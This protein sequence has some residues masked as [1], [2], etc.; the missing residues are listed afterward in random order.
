MPT[1]EAKLVEVIRPCD[2]A[3]RDAVYEGAE[4]GTAAGLVDAEDVWAGCGGGGGVVGVGLCH[5]S[6]EHVSRR[7]LKYRRCGFVQHCSFLPS[8]E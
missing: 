5:V 4:D 7:A 1:C 6:R 8:L 2:R 3:V